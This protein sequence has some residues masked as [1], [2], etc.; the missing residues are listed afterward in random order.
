MKRHD[1]KQGVLIQNHKIVDQNQMEVINLETLMNS[2]INHVSDFHLNSNQILIVDGPYIDMSP[3]TQDLDI[4]EIVKRKVLNA[5]HEAH[6]LGA[7]EIIFLSN[8]IPNINISFYDDDFLQKSIS[9]WKHMIKHSKD[10][11]ISLC[12]TFEHNPK[13][14]LDIYYGISSKRF[15]LAFDM[16]H[17]LAYATIDLNAFYEQI[18]PYIHTV[19][20]HSNDQKSDAHLSILKGNLLKQTSTLKIIKD[21]KDIHLIFKSFDQSDVKKQLEQIKMILD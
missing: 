12:N 6:R 9:F 19:Y 13:M 1:I 11:T 14:M 20:I 7:K 2:N 8:Y 4:F 17:A 16:G 18:K 21:F 5:I 10:I 3:A 15:S